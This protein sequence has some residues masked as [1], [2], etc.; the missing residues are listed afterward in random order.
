MIT[1]ERFRDLRKIDVPKWL[2]RR[3]IETWDDFKAHLE[4]LEVAIPEKHVWEEIKPSKVLVLKLTENTI[5]EE[6][7]KISVEPPTRV[8]SRS[9]KKEDAED[10]KS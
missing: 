5:Q 4:L 9:R 1:W 7:V 10:Q 8:R 6:H 2:S 3:S